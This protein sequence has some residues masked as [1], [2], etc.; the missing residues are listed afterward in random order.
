MEIIQKLIA[1]KGPGHLFKPAH[2]FLALNAIREKGPIG[3]YELGRVLDLGGGSIRTLVNRMK[4]E[5]LILV[6]GKKGH[7]LTE[8]GE[9]VLNQIQKVLVSI[10]ELEIAEKL[11]SQKF[12][13]GCQ[14]RNISAKI[15]SGIGMR[16][17]AIS[18]GGS[19]ITSLIY[20]G[21][22]F[23]IPTLGKDYLE[24]EHPQLSDYL[25]SRFKLEKDDVI[26]IC[27]AN[28]FIGAQLGSVTAILF[29]LTS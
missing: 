6:D 23:N 20:T 25:L 4:E 10:R 18:V 3:R 5:N 16:D 7:V 19:S 9:H 1:R 22:N 11:T 8:M 21:S 15:G 24:I 12:N 27:G 26:V 29:L 14:A 13:F 28:S 2:F 17:A